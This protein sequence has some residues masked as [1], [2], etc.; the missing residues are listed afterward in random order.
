MQ[1]SFSYGSSVK[2]P[3]FVTVQG[4]SNWGRAETEKSAASLPAAR[5][6]AS[7]PMR[8]IG[9][10]FS[11]FSGRRSGSFVVAMTVSASVGIVFGFYPAWKASRLDP[12]DAL[13]YE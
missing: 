5:C 9:A 12:I 13:R 2:S 6:T 4:I 11:R 8:Q 10:V 7:A 3:S 1:S